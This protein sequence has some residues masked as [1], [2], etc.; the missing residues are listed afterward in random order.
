[1]CTYC[2]CCGDNS[3]IISKYWNLFL[4]WLLCF[5][6]LSHQWLIIQIFIFLFSYWIMLVRVAIWLLAINVGLLILNIFS[7]FKLILAFIF[8]I[9]LVKLVLI[10]LFFISPNF[11]RILVVWFF[12]IQ[13]N[14]LANNLFLKQ[15]SI[16]YFIYF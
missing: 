16:Q 15:K 2:S 12:H 7:I 14:Y 13:M 1:M 9:N 10:L 3:L 11:R 6:I 5:F 8:I 4:I